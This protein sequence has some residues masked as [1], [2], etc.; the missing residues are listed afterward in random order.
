MTAIPL[1]MPGEWA[2]HAACKGVD[3]NVF[4]PVRGEDLGAA[5]SYCEGCPVRAECLDHALRFEPHGVWGGTSAKQR[6]RMR[7]AAGIT[8]VDFHR[9]PADLPETA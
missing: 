8:L 4:H 7:R 6:I 9:R 5:R 2:D 3:P 1:L